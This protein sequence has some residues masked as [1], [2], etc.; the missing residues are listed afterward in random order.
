M[1]VLIIVW[2]L[3]VLRHNGHVHLVGLSGNAPQQRGRL[4]QVSISLTQP[5]PLPAST[6]MT[7]SAKPI[8]Q[9][10]MVGRGSGLRQTK[11]LYNYMLQVHRTLW[12]CPH[13]KYV[14]PTSPKSS[15]SSG[16]CTTYLRTSRWLQRELRYGYPGFELTHA[17]A[18]KISPS[19]VSTM[20][21]YT[22]YQ[23]S[24]TAAC[25]GNSQLV[26]AILFHQVA[27]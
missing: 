1:G 20:Q 15:R 8:A 24:W 9:H 16:Q 27:T 17:L 18:I 22:S 5:A 11:Y 23:A 25:T 19:K 7:S 14:F 3:P 6:F 10:I 2:L 12:I 26:S 13:C 21:W 4:A